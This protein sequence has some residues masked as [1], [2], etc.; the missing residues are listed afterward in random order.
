M[1]IVSLA[2]I[3]KGHD[4][5]LYIEDFSGHNNNLD[6]EEKLFG[7]P[8]YFCSSHYQFIMQSALDVLKNTSSYGAEFSMPERNESMWKGYLCSVDEIMVYGYVTTTGLR[9]L[10]GIENASFS[11]NSNNAQE[12]REANLF[13]FTRS[14]HGAYIEY[15][16]NPLNQRNQKIHSPAFQNKVK[17]FLNIFNESNQALGIY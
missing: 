2:V 7:F 3:G 16:L 6:L 9:I 8:R 14:I 17:S 15:L 1:S 11:Y 13:A 4:E 12:K 10:V 5:P